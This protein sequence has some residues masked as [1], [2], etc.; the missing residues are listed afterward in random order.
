M[1]KGQNGVVATSTPK[2]EAGTSS[3]P[4]SIANTTPTGTT[5]K[6]QAA[7]QIHNSFNNEIKDAR[8]YEG[9]DVEQ[10]FKYDG[11][12]QANASGSLNNKVETS[13]NANRANFKTNFTYNLSK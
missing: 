8:N 11:I 1:A 13:G 9:G 6:S 12:G 2:T 3:T 4:S 7:Q 5:S 10:N